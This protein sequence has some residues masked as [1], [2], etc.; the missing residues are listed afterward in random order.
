MQTTRT[1]A[2]SVASY[3][4]CRRIMP[5]SVSANIS[6]RIT[7]R[8]ATAGVDSCLLCTS[9]GAVPPT[10]LATGRNS[11]FP[12]ATLLDCIYD[13]HDASLHANPRL[14]SF[15]ALPAG[16]PT[17]CRPRPLPAAQSSSRPRR[18]PAAA[19]AAPR[20]AL[21]LLLPS[22]PP[23]WCVCVTAVIKQIY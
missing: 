7:Q 8:N 18:R 23:A 20:P 21:A 11:H 2:S 6:D 12:F 15:A 10:P 22:A 19:A 1:A 5:P 17:P 16:L 3:L 13:T 14:V 4:R 9:T